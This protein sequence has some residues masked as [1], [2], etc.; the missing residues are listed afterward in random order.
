MV[1]RPPS[2]KGIGSTEPHKVLL[3]GHHGWGKTWQVRNFAERYG[4]GLLLSGEKG[5]KSLSDIDIPHVAFTSW[6]GAHDPDNNVY[7]FRGMATMLTRDFIRD[8]NINWLAL[9]SIT[10]LSEMLMAWC[11]HET[12]EEKNRF[13][14]WTLYGEKMIGAIKWIRDLP[15]H[16]YVTSLA[17][18]TSDDGGNDY[19]PH[20]HGNKVGVAIP[21]NFDHVFCAIRRDDTVGDEVK[22]TRYIV[23]EEMNGWHGKVR[24]PWKRVKAVEQCDDI[25]E[26]LERMTRTPEEQAK[27]EELLAKVKADA[28][29][30]KAA[31]SEKSAA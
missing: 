25:T 19:W 27:H 30:V 13:A 12:R 11:K 15:V 31:A 29:A 23:S 22:T 17:A 14:V 1:W 20:V 5:L 21:A 7:S 26:L 4:N 8:N 16:V 2:T 24:D 6:D 3:Y 18:S 10:E 9:D 28:V